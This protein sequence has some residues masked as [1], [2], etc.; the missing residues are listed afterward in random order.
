M[1][2]YFISNLASLYRAVFKFLNWRELRSF[3]ALFNNTNKIS[4]FI[5]NSLIPSSVMGILFITYQSDVPIE[6]KST[7]E[8]KISL[9][10]SV[11]F[12]NISTPF[13]Q[14]YLI[15]SIVNKQK[16]KFSAKKRY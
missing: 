12:Y 7:R 14:D 10:N 11:F 8:L 16:N 13:F 4:R 2:E 3:N 1:V 6:I 5:I 15:V 9:C